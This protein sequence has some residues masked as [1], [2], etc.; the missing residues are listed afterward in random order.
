VAGHALTPATRHRLGGPLPH[1]LA[2]RPRADPGPPELCPAEHANRRG[3]PVLAT[4]SRCY[5]RVQG[6][7]PTR[8]SPVR[9]FRPEWLPTPVSTLDLHV[10]GAPPAFI[11]SQDQTLRRDLNHEMNA[12]EISIALYLG[13]ITSTSASAE[14][15]PRIF[16]VDLT[17]R[18]PLGLDE[19][20]T[21]LRSTRAFRVSRQ[22]HCLVLKEPTPKGHQKTPEQPASP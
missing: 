20:H 6:T 3:H 2:D 4:V 5:P 10:L 14:H 13:S 22:A 7:L 11:L 12:F 19:G 21:D 16:V 9:R 15:S 18:A 8:Y 17:E 1:Q